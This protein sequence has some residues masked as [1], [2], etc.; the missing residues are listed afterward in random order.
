MNQNQR[1]LKIFRENCQIFAKNAC[2]QKLLLVTFYVKSYLAGTWFAQSS[3]TWYFTPGA[4]IPGPL[5]AAPGAPN[6]GAGSLAQSVVISSPPQDAS[7][8]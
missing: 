3:L 1:L 6:P 8:I 4:A 5:A 2:D 7:S